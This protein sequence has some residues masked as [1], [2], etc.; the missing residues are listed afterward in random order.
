MFHSDGII[1]K[2]SSVGQQTRHGNLCD[3]EDF[4]L[5]RVVGRLNG[6]SRVSE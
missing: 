1:Y 4:D 5:E 2:A 3:F 6:N